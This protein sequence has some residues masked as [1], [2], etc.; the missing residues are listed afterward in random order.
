MFIPALRHKYRLAD[1]SPLIMGILNVTPDSFSDGGKLFTGGTNIESVLSSAELMITNGAHILDIGGESTR[2]GAEV[3][4]VEQELS[5]VVPAIE[6]IKASFDCVVSIDTSRPDVMVA[7]VKAGA[8]MINDVRGLTLDGA[9]EAAI[10]ANVPVCLMHMKGTPRNMQQLPEY[11]DVVTD[12]LGYLQSRAAEFIAQGGN[13]EHIIL[14]PGFGFGK[15]LGHNQALFRALP[16]FKSASYPVL[17]GVSRKSMLGQLTGKPVEQR[18]TS[19]ACAALLAA[20]YG[21][22]VIRVHD[23]AETADALAVLAGLGK[24]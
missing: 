3:V 6:A 8:D 16:R 22:D 21:A 15:A 23:V 7:A 2:P 13:P 9:M 11:D 5:R 24:K 18:A 4:T 10:A 14:D 1:S 19:S 17:V 20:Q 12:V